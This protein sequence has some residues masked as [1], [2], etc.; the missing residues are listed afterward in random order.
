[1]IVCHFYDRKSPGI[2][3]HQHIST[4][5]YQPPRIN[6][7]HYLTYTANIAKFPSNWAIT[8]TQ[9]LFNAT[10]NQFTCEMNRP[11]NPDDG[12]NKA[13]NVQDDNFI[14]S[15]SPNSPVNADGIH[16]SYHT[17]DHRGA[18]KGSLAMGLLLDTSV[19]SYSEKQIH[20]FGMVVVSQIGFFFIIINRL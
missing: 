16:F 10:A 6:I 1:M 5:N 18:L 7:F 20:G 17:V 11:L 8:P 14:W 15:F 3:I 13:I 4:Q 12:R 2:Q 9:G 19:R